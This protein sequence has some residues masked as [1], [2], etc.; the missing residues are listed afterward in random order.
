MGRLI[1]ADMLKEILLKRVKT[2]R[3]TM[4]IKRDIIPLIDDQPTVFRGT[5][6]M[7]DQIEKSK[8]DALSQVCFP[9]F[10][11]KDLQEF[12][13]I[14]FDEAIRIVKGELSAEKSNE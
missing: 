4:E 12:A 13:D 9:R 10:I 5:Q 7:V 14:C 3:S 8:K 6:S 2:P 11:K 1:D